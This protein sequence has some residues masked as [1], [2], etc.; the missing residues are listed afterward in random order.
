MSQGRLLFVAALCLAAG[1][2]GCRKSGPTGEST[3]APSA[4]GRSSSAPLDRLGPGELAPGDE[5]IFGLVLPRGML[6]R[7]HFPGT[8]HAVGPMTPEDMANYLRDRVDAGRIEI[9]AVGTVF[10]EVHIKGGDPSKLY[11]LE[12]HAAGSG[13]EL[14][15]RD[16]TPL[17]KP[18]PE[19]GISETE[20]WRRA[21]YLPN[22][23][24][25][26]PMNLR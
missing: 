5:T 6:L 24:P 8:A 15:L 20:R 4:N 16:V 22:G 13:T 18:E 1:A 14:E 2:P 26:D 17:P 12:V 23:T 3:P 19:P 7:A 11:R 9:G 25:I 10:P 21:G